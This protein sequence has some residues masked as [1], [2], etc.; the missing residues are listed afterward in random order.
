MLSPIRVTSVDGSYTPNK[1][2]HVVGE[3]RVS[4]DRLDIACK[5]LVTSL[6]GSYAPNKQSHVVGEDRVS[7]DRLGIACKLHEPNEKVIDRE[8]ERICK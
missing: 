1:K 3:D 6:D 2:S 5:L 7:Y 8:S 4:Y